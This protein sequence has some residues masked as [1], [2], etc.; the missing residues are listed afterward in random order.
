MIKKLCTLLLL[1]CTA[2]P[3]LAQQY[4]SNDGASFAPKKGQW[5][6]SVLLGNG[7]FF[8]E[9]T[10]YL[11]PRNTNTTGEVGLPNGGTDHSGDLNSYLNIGGLNTNSLVNL[12]GIEG[13]YFV[14]DSWDI[15]FQFSMNISL[16]PKKDY[17][18]GDG[19]VPDMIIPAQSYIN[20]QMTNNWYTSIGSNYYFKTRNERIHP[21]IGAALGFQMARIETTEP[22][23]G[24]TFSESEKPEESAPSESTELPEQVYTAGSKAGQ[25]YGFK[26]AAVAGIEYSIAKG[27]VFG[28]E[29]QPLAYRYDVIQIC[30][31]GFDTYNV[32]HHNIKIFEM[33]MVKLGFR[34]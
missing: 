28:F 10:S 7:K 29:M 32:S 20:A 5:Q 13:K 31:K 16:T 14:S 26:A 11:L 33:P 34:F 22:Y 24:K 30:P 12:A 25:M 23:T 19:K 6:V 1:T 15:N 9:N 4:S 21:Y 17:V 8:N 18:E 27:F 3:I 2:A